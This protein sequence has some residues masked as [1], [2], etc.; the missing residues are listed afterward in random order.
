M[1]MK[2]T[3]KLDKFIDKLDTKFLQFDQKLQNHET[4]L[5][6]LEVH[7]KTD[8]KKDWKSDIIILLVK[9]VLIGGVAIAS[10]AGAGGVISKI[11]T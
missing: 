9:A 6:V 5:V 8:E 10:L 11:F 1:Y 2:L 3:E 4:R 7:D